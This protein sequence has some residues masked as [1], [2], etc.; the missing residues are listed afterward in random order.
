MLYVTC[1]KYVKYCSALN[2]TFNAH[3]CLKIYMCVISISILYAFTFVLILYLV[4][5][6]KK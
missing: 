6:L 4:A 5:L 3:T 2:I 1:V